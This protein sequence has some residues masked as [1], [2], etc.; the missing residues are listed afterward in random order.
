VDGTIKNLSG[1][2]SITGTNGGPGRE[3]I[4]ERM[5]QFGLRVRF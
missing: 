4:D 5:W 2:R 1:F 3:G